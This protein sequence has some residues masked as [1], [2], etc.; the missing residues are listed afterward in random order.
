MHH[1]YFIVNKTTDKV[2]VGQSIGWKSRVR[3]HFYHLR[4]GSHHCLHLQ[5]AFD[6][7]GD[8][9]FESYV[10]S[11]SMTK[12]ECDTAERFYIEWFRS[13]GLSYNSTG[14]GDGCYLPDADLREKF[15]Q[16]RKGKRNSD[17]SR[18]KVS[19]ALK[20]RVL[21]PMTEEKK[22]KI[23]ATLTGRKTG[24]CSE[25]RK[26]AISAAK[27]G[28]PVP[29]LQ[30]RKLSQE[31][32][33]RLREV[34]T[35][36]TKSEETKRRISEARKGKG[37]GPRSEETRRKISEA[38]AARYAD[39]LT[40]GTEWAYYGRGCRCDVCEAAVHPSKVKAEP[41]IQHGTKWAYEKHGCRCDACKEAK[42]ASR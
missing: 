27:M 26:Q 28:K 14:G 7:Y 12:E 3:N 38:A 10:V 20:G 42:R 13:I 21:S 4:E 1:I 9:V 40:H 36:R 34:N 41:V 31:Q 22:A 25:E 15:S 24:P 35:G 8:G 33:D 17:E 5:R 30:G 37:T 6:K 11:Q 29:A 16:S 2:Y 18:R 39:K 19:E 23:S 32:I